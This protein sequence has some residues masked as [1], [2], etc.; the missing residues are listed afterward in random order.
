MV[1]CFPRSRALLAGLVQCT[2]CVSY[3]RQP[4]PEMSAVS[5][6]NLARCHGGRPVPSLAALGAA[7]QRAVSVI[8]N[9]RVGCCCHHVVPRALLRRTPAGKRHSTIKS[10]EAMARKPWDN[11]RSL[12]AGRSYATRNRL[13]RLGRPRTGCRR[14]VEGPRDVC[15]RVDGFAYR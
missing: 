9:R 1:T 7:A 3:D 15:H 14:N 6:A 5:A 12:E 11:E 10:L 4:P 2:N 13:A 8:M